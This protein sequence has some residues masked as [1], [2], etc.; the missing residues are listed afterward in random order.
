MIIPE[1]IKD[2]FFFKEKR[3]KKSRAG[4]DIA[5][6]FNPNIQEVKAGAEVTLGY[7]ASS[8]TAWANIT[9]SKINKAFCLIPS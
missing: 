7:L 9:L 5:H 2:F 8:K 4:H 1:L 3:G 6:S